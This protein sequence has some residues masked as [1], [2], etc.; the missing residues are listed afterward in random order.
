MRK[1]T[2]P[3]KNMPQKQASPPPPPKPRIDPARLEEFLAARVTVKDGAKI[4]DIQDGFL[5]E[6]EGLQRYRINVWLQKDS[7]EKVIGASFFVHYDKNKKV[8][9]D[10]TIE[11]KT[12]NSRI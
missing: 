3:K 7:G 1:S 8:I 2:A 11:R 10:K 5:W 9:T 12:E 4:C 6:T